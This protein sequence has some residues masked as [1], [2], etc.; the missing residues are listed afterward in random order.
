MSDQKRQNK[1]RRSL[2]TVFFMF[3]VTLVFISV[4]SLI[5]VL[6]RDI[7]RLNE[8]LVVKRAVLYV[9]GLEVPQTGIEADAMYKE[10]VKEV[11]D[12]SGNVLYYEILEPSGTNVQSYVVPVL[13]AGLWGEIESVVGVEKDLK[14]LTGIEFIKQNETPGLGGRITESWFK[15]QFRGKHWPLSVVPEGDPAGDQEF[16]AITGATNTTNGIRDI[17]NNRLAKAE[18]AIQASK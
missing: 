4:L 16:Q 1:L 9:A 8:S 17:L 3:A 5:Y 6:T 18:Q 14:T 11:K 2:F 15:E 10:R 7:I 13:G 12:E